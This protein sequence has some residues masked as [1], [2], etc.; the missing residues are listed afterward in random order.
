VDTDSD[1][2]RFNM[3]HQQIR[4]WDV[5]DERVLGVMEALRREPFVPDAYQG[6]AYADIEVPLEGGRALLAPKVVGRMLQALAVKPGDKVLEIGSGTGY[7]TVCLCRLGGRVMGLEPDATLAAAAREHLA[8]LDCPGSE[9]LEL[10]PFSDPIPGGP[11][12]VVAVNGSLPHLEA[13]GP[14]EQQLAAGGRLFCIVGEPP[15]MGAFLVTR[16]GPQGFRRETRF[17]TSAAPLTAAPPLPEF[18]F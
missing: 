15:V 1:R 5:L 4:P 8:D 17:E 7:G 13:L 12:N 6:L 10:D 3:I 16:L 14:F 9:I 18:V 11:F 2:A